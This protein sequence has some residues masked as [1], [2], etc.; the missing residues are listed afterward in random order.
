MT[1]S[2]THNYA[3]PIHAP[4]ARIFDALTTQRELER[5]FAEHAR[6]DPR[7]GGTFRFWGRHTVGTPSERE[8]RGK[9]MGL[10]KDKRIAFEWTVYGVPGTVTITL[11]PEDSDRG[12]ATK[13]AVKHELRGMPDQ[14]RPRELIDDWWRFSLGNL[15]AHV[16]GHGEVLRPDFADDNPEIRLS[17]TVAA[18]REAVFRA[19][20]EPDALREWM[21]APAP[22]VEPRVGGRY[23]LGWTYTVEGAEVSGGPMKILDI[24]P[25]ERLVV[26]WPDWRGDTS[27]P[28]QSITWELEPHGSGTRVTLIHAGFPRTVDFSDYPFGWGHFMSEMA[29]VAIRLGSDA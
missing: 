2:W 27:V 16:M 25:D 17:M 4:A 11:T 19:L 28:M 23:E 24:V 18:P 22:V 20:T 12:P 6:V 14:P 3:L 15:M 7:V 5:W 21:G 13:V 8:A 26:S 10:E 29:K 9:V 1:S